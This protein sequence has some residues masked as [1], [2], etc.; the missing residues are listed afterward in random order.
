M[1][2]ECTNAAARG[3]G[4]SGEKQRGEDGCVLH[5]SVVQ[6]LGLLW[7]PLACGERHLLTG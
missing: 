6:S 4:L 3:W 5:S 1:C 7:V 2:T